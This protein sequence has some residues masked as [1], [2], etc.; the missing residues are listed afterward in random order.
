MKA[1]DVRVLL[2]VVVV[3]AL[4]VDNKGQLSARSRRDS[5]DVSCSVVSQRSGTI[6]QTKQSLAAG[7]VF[8]LSPA[9]DSQDDCLSACCNTPSCNLAIVKWK[10]RSVWLC[11]LRSA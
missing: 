5:S 8:L 4:V 6:I 11:F 7:A 3:L 2:A 10:V 1:V 9:I